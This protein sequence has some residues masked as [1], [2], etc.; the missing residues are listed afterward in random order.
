[1]FLK[2]AQQE[3]NAKLAKLNSCKT[4][5]EYWWWLLMNNS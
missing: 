3:M 2:M 4:W 1:M 5:S